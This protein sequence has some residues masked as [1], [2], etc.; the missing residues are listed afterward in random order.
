MK[1]NLLNTQSTL[2]A[3]ITL[4]NIPQ[5]SLAESSQWHLRPYF[6]ISQL[7]DTSGS[8]TAVSGT[9]GTTDIDLDS[10]FTAGASIG[11]QYTDQV[12]VELATEYRSN[13]SKT[14]LSDGQRFEDGNYA[15]VTFFLN[16]A[17]RFRTTQPWQ[18]YIGTGLGWI[19]EVD[20]DLEDASGEISY[21]SDGFAWQAF[22]GVDM[23]FHDQWALNVE[24]RHS[25]ASSIDL[26]G[27]TGN[28]GIRGLDYNPTTLQ[29]GLRYGF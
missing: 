27:E 21:E 24:L 17:Y 18:P 11:Y 23:P 16:A 13:E 2:F 5:L 7:S 25:R 29:L 8:A 28:E 15:S 4:L 1:S 26:E 9:S 22:V 14:L 12:S 3:L 20:I 10:G 19:Q 6:G